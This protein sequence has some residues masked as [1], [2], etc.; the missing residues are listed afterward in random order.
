ML[1]IISILFYVLLSLFFSSLF[2]FYAI[3]I[4]LNDNL[5]NDKLA[6]IRENLVSLYA[7]TRKFI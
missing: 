1:S 3:D 7:E 2:F 5:Y 4:P 6:G